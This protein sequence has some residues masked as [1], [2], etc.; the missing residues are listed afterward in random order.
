MEAGRAIARGIM[1]VRPDAEITVRPLADGGEGTVDA[2]TEGISNGERICARVSG[3]LGDR[4]S[5][6][7][8]I[9]NGRTAVIETASAAGLTLIPKEKRDPMLASTYGLGELISDAI[10]R[11]VRSFLIGLG[12]SATNDGGVGMLSALGFDFR[13]GQGK[14]I[15]PCARG[16][17]SLH[18]VSAE[19]A[20]PEL[21]SCRFHIASDVD[22]PL[23]GERGASAVFSPQKGARAEDICEMDRLLS[24]YA[25]LSAAIYPNVDPNAR[26]AGAA[27]GLGFAFLTYLGAELSPGAELIISETCLE[28]HIIASDV[29]ITGE[30]RID[31]Q[32][33]MGKAPA[34][35]AFLAKKHQKRTVAF[36]GC[37]GEGAD[38]C[39][40]PAFDAIVSITQIPTPEDMKK[41][42][43]EKNLSAAASRFFK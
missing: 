37:T 28:D 10:G 15:E 22:N 38:A 2:L 17:R 42:R 26:G 30:G 18:T 19:N 25:E 23:C 24:H 14:R 1:A 9:I 32:T 4:I 13:D 11:G 43:A 29:V 35:L 3:P 36:C 21:S 12:G 31:R 16:L 34:T 8:V 39:I 27:G 5:A 41:D 6:E 20:L 7:Y 40:G 33:L